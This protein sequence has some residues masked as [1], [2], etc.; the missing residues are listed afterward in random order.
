VTPRLLG[1]IFGI[2]RRALA[3]VRIGL[4]GAILVDLALRA[5]SLRAMVTDRGFLPRGAL[6][7]WMRETIFP[8]HL[9]SGSLRSQQALLAA[10]AAAALLLLV[11]R[12]TRIAAL[13]TWV[14]LVSLHAR[15]PLILNFGDAILRVSTF[16]AL[17]LPL[18]SRWSLDARRARGGRDP[19]PVC[20]V[21]SA[22]FLLQV[23]FVYFFTA[24]EKSG[25]D[26]HRDGLALYY[27]LHLDWMALPPAHWLRDQV[28]LTQLVTWATLA[29]EYVGPFLLLAP[30]WPLR[31]LGVLGF[32]SLHLGISATLRLGVFPW[33][34]IAILAAFLPREVW[35]ALERP[36]R[37]AAVVAARAPAARPAAPARLA[38][39]AGSALLAAL[40]AI[41]LL[42]NV[43]GVSAR[44][45]LPE[46]V[47]RALRAAGLEQRW[48]MFSPDTPRLDGWYVMPGRLA[49]G[50]LV[51]LSP[52]GPAL[53]WAKPARIPA[54][55]PTAR[56]GILLMHQLANQQ[57][58]G[59]LR[60]SW[61][62]FLCREWN[63][64]HPPAEQLERVDVFLM[65]ERTV[66][67]GERQDV[68]P[69]YM[70]AHRCPRPGAPESPGWDVTVRESGAPPAPL[71]APP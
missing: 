2:D 40:V 27:A 38:A 54:D 23:C 16:W 32:W 49:D 25:P 65:L 24:V 19:G 50:R 31:L 46:S 37:S 44:V 41:V 48:E 22:A 4:A 64:K 52:H 28:L 12:F 56:W 10:A 58:N 8:L 29:F 9:L 68:V 63:R 1:R 18:G 26:W 57:A 51:N 53:D 11:G 62:R 33:V 59:W 14:L 39:R 55:L 43:A 7:P 6:D 15:N 3:A 21:A 70:A 61:V 45:S 5:G 60:R 67:P 20:S 35:D 71:V 66:P 42:A 17:F 34:D 30:A 69:R 47:A 13:A 36:F